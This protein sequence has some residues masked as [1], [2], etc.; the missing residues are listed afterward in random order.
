[1]QPRILNVQISQLNVGYIRSPIKVDGLQSLQLDLSQ[2]V[3]SFELDHR[4]LE[5]I[6]PV[7]CIQGVDETQV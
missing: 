2:V 6:K 3:Q 7:P 1:M 4:W 5:T